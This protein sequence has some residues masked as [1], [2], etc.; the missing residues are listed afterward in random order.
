MTKEQKISAYNRLQGA[1][2]VVDE[3]VKL[4][5]PEPEVLSE[6][7]L[8]YTGLKMAQNNLGWDPGEKVTEPHAK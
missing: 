1:M 8:A 7:M 5:S 6:L 4:Y 3:M 2:A